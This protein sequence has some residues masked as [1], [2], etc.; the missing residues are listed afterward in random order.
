[1]LLEVPVHDSGC[2]TYGVNGI[3]TG[4]EFP[5]TLPVDPHKEDTP[6]SGY[7]QN[8]KFLDQVGTTCSSKR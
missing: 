1:M 4:I 6:A 8:T 3:D 7:Q 2:N 5:W